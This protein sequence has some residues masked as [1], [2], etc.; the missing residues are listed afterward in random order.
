MANHVLGSKTSYQFSCVK[1]NSESYEIGELRASGGFW[2]TFF[3]YNK[4]RFYFLSC[5]ECGHTEF[6]NRQLGKGQKL[7][8]LLTG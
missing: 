8:D 5:S 2:S 4:N 3:N 1:C 7:F 6:Y